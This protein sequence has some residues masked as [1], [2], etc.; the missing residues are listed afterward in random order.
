M[1]LL[2][3]DWI[4]VVKYV[5]EVCVFYGVFVDKVE[6]IDEGYIDMNKYYIWMFILYI[7][8]DVEIVQIGIVNFIFYISFIVYGYVMVGGMFKNISFELYSK[9]V[10]NDICKGWFVD[11]DFIY[12]GGLMGSVVLF[13]YVNLKYMW[14]DLEGNNCNDLCYMCVE[15]M[16]LIEVE[17][18]VM[19]GNIVGGKLLLE[20]FVKIC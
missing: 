5:K 7:I 6:L 12:E 8:M 2:K 15:E 9:I 17:V 3:E 10:D 19:G 1:Y 14:Y 18:L 13:K 11:K 4:N 20:E 16:W